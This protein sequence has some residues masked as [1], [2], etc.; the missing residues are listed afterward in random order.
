[1]A[2]SISVLWLSLS[3]SEYLPILSPSC[4]WPISFPLLLVSSLPLSLSPILSLSLLPFL[5]LSPSYLPH[6]SG[7]SSPSTSLLPIS[8]YFNHSPIPPPISSDCQ[9]F[10]EPY[11]LDHANCFR[12][13]VPGACSALLHKNATSSLCGVL[14][15]VDVLIGMLCAFL[16]A[17]Y[18]R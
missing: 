12:H 11:C 15:L 2:F 13:G 9:F 7:L 16:K 8:L 17:F 14:V 5:I 4:R 6:V 3:R 18:T 1:M 10:Q